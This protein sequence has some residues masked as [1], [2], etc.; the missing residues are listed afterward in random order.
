MQFR[1]LN[2]EATTVDGIERLCDLCHP[3]GQKQHPRVVG[4]SDPSEDLRAAGLPVRLGK[5]GCATCH[6]MHSQDV[7]PADVRKPYVE[8]AATSPAS[9]PHGNRAACRACHPRDLPAGSPAVFQES[10]PTKRCVGCHPEDHTKIHPVGVAP[11]E[12]TYPMS[13][14]QYPLNPDGTIG[15]STCHDHPCDPTKPPTGPSFLRGGPYITFTDF[16]YRCHPKAGKGGLNPHDQVDSKGN[17]VSGTCTFCHKTAPSGDAYDPSE[18]LYLRSPIELCTRCH[19]QGPHPTANH[20]VEVPEEMVR[21][22][23]TYQKRHKVLLPLDDAG[24]IVCTTCHNPHAK[25]VLRGEA[26]L[27]AGELHRWR[28][29]SYA[30]LCT[31]CHTRYD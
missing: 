7:G 31:P 16:C 28:V 15:C 5:V 30:E 18:L 26:A 19:D 21:R 12:K 2:G 3:K 20:L 22:L 14:L 29:P 27:G 9:Y 4:R 13:F 10:D 23:E 25:G 17:V 11:S 8:F 24:R 1:T 6:D